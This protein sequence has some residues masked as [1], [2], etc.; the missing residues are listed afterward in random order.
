M[1]FLKKMPVLQLITLFALTLG[2]FFQLVSAQ[3]I[4]VENEEEEQKIRKFVDTFT[5]A[6]EETKDLD[7]LPANYFVSDFKERFSNTNVMITDLPPNLS[8]KITK[9]EAYEASIL[10]LNY[11]YL[12]IM[13][14]SG[15]CCE[16]ETKDLYPPEILKFMEKNQFLSQTLLNADDDIQPKIAEIKDF[17]TLMNEMKS[18]INFERQYINSRSAAWKENYRKNIAKTR[19]NFNSFNSY[20]CSGKDCENLP[21]K[22]QMTEV[23]AFPFILRIVKEGEN[24]KIL[25]I[26]PYSQ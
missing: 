8:G 7:K 24:Y 26:Y 1:T 4:T 13:S 6:F 11:S 17:H 21:E 23:S 12:G 5:N 10:G 25:G 2:L 19:E 9:E 22:T 3:H 15:L 14:N 16:G 18:L 20:L